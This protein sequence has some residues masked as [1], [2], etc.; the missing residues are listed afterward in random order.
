MKIKITGELPSPLNPPSGCAFHKR[1][2]HATALCSTEEPLLRPL[3]GREVA[4]H[5]AETINPA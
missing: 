2:P 4:C 5:H 1:C 3:L